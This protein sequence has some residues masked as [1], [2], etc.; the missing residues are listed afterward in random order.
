MCLQV[1]FYL[2]D[3][4]RHETIQWEKYLIKE[5]IRVGANTFACQNMHG[6]GLVYQISIRNFSVDQA[7][8]LSGFLG[9]PGQSICL[10]RQRNISSLLICYSQTCS[11]GIPFFF[12]FLSETTFCFVLFPLLSFFVYYFAIQIPEL[13]QLAYNKLV[14][15]P[16]Q[17]QFT[18]PEIEWKFACFWRLFCKALVLYVAYCITPRSCSS[19][20]SAHGV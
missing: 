14:F 15:T 11:A 3:A 5:G 13:L 8:R 6:C 1:F 4:F 20:L 2:K 19:I 17:V 16:G 10:R 7:R 12:F 18:S 9:G